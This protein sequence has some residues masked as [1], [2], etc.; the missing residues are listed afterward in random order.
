MRRFVADYE[1]EAEETLPRVVWNFYRSGS[2][3]GSTVA[4]NRQIFHNYLILPRGLRDVS[5]SDDSVSLL[6]G[7]IRLNS[8]ICVSP[9]AFH[10]FAYPDGEKATAA[11]KF[12]RFHL[13]DTPLT[14]TMR[15]KFRSL[16][17]LTLIIF[18]HVS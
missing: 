14:H 13:V 4:R 17:T 12:S 1:R 7:S 6:N 16:D 9:L 10:G 5:N 2:E 11:G 15:L 3:L 18:V 8:P